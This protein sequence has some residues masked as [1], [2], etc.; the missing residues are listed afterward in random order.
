MKPFRSDCREVFVISGSYR[1]EDPLTPLPGSGEQRKG[2]EK[3][4][5]EGLVEMLT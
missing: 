3:E 1:M 5:K 2:E 4:S